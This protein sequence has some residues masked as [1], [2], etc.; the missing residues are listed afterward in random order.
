[1]DLSRTQQIERFKE[2]HDLSSNILHG[3]IIECKKCFGR[4]YNG[5]DDDLKQFLP[6]D[7]IIKAQRKAVLEN[8]RT[9]NLNE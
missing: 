3:K 1:M 8:F 2:M 6:C 7:C 4:G 9:G 5:W